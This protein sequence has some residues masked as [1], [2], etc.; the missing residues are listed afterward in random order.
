LIDLLTNGWPEDGLLEAETCSH[1]IE[2][3]IEVVFDGLLLILNCLSCAINRS[4]K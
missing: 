2:Y 3:N 4:L 1:P